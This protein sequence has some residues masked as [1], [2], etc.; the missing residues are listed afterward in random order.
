VNYLPRFF[1]ASSVEVLF[2]IIGVQEM[3]FAVWLIVKGFN[4]HMLAP[5]SAE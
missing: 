4:R 2:F 3:V 5:E 1:G